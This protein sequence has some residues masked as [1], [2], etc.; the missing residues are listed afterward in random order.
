MIVSMLADSLN[1]TLA[2]NEATPM[3]NGTK[4]AVLAAYDDLFKIE[5]AQGNVERLIQVDTVL[6]SPSRW[7][8]D[9]RAKSGSWK[10]HIVSTRLLLAIRAS[11][12]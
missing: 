9:E 12:S 4:A 5:D 3:D 7:A 11:A 6:T 10:I 1:H 8:K 2:H